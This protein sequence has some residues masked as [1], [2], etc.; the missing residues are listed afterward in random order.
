MFVDEIAIKP[1]WRWLAIFSCVVGY[2][3]AALFLGCLVL[4]TLGLILL[5]VLPEG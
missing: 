4:Y 1:G 3:L 2:A 5:A